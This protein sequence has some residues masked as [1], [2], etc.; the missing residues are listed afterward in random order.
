[1]IKMIHQ[2]RSFTLGFVLFIL[3][4][5]DAFLPPGRSRAAPV[6]LLAKKKKKKTPGGS[7]ITVNRVARRNYEVLDT[8]E[9]GISLL[10]TEVK[11][12]RD[13]KMQLRDAYVKCKNFR[14]CILVNCHI[15][16][17]SNVG[18][19]FQHEERRP[20]PLLVHKE[21]ARKWQQKT[22]VRSVRARIAKAPP[23]C[24]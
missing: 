6:S 3:V 14:S 13:G 20:R 7:T 9:A 17:H 8:L 21:E 24:D 12:T 22:E 10:G 18:E 16:K 2:W 4:S 5:T 23:F 1:M 15:G 19:Y 11:S